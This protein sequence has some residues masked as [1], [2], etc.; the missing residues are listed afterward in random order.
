MNTRTERFLTFIRK[1]KTKN[2]L[3][4]VLYF[5]IVL[6]NMNVPLI[7]QVIC[8]I[9]Q[10]F[11]ITIGCMLYMI[12]IELGIYKE[13]KHRK[14]YKTTI[15]KIFKEMLM[16]IPILLISNCI[17]SLFC[18]GDPVN[19]TYVVNL[20]KESPIFNSILIV[21]IGP[22]IEEFSFRFLPYKFIQNKTLYIIISSVV[23]AM[24]H[25]IDDPNAFYYIWFYMIHPLYYAY[26]Y[27]KTKDILVPISMHSFNNLI[28][29][30]LVIF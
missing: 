18:I 20:F 14:K 8:L 2:F 19:Q 6:M 22:I 9:T 4:C 27:H 30:L 15:K 10:M 23:F 26:R 21:I 29:I 25:V 7:F 17:I 24:M 1:E 3:A 12:D 5:S 16:F 28:C 11:I 13:T